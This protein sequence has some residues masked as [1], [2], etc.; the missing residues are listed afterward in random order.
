MVIYYIT[1]FLFTLYAILKNRCDLIHV[2]W[3]IPTGPIGV[4]A[5]K[6]LRKPLIVTI[7]GSDLRMAIAGPS[8]L[9]RIFV[10]VCRK[11]KHIHSVSE[12]MKREI[13]EMGISERK[14]S[15]WP[16]G[17]DE[18]FLQS[19]RD[20]RKRSEGYPI[21]ILSN[22]NLLPLYN[23]SCL[24]R[25]IPLVL[26]EEPEVRF[27]IAGEGAEKESLEEETRRLQ[28][29]SATH[30]LGR[31]PHEQMPDLL[32]RTNIFVSTSLSDGTSVSLME[33]LASGAFPVV[34]DIPSNREWINDGENGFLVPVGSE[35]KLAGRIV[36]AIRNVELV[37]RASQRN[38]KIVR[39][40]AYWEENIDK[41]VEIYGHLLTSE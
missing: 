3:A 7:H 34:T 25:A 36:E 2:H 6:L 32:G 23:V 28:V 38:Q 11:A 35:I 41:M 29:C 22:R 31:I 39:E 5:G 33:A 37:E 12:M 30:F 16:M 19:G 27:L 9:K 4:M 10:Y 13:E 14:I 15:I 26:K 24:I 20:R 1:G 17:V 40:K 8:V 21:T 18:A